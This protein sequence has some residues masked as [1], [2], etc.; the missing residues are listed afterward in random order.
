MAQERRLGASVKPLSA[1]EIRAELA[2]LPEEYRTS[3][4]LLLFS[5]YDAGISAGLAGAAR[6]TNPFLPPQAPKAKGKAR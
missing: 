5:A 3:A 4:L 6:N 1:V 2:R